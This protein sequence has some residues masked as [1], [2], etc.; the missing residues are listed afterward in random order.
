MYVLCTAMTLRP[1]P[2]S[3]SP[4]QL[5]EVL[6]NASPESNQIYLL[7]G[8]C[9]RGKGATKT[10][11]LV[12]PVEGKWQVYCPWSGMF[13]KLTKKPL[14]LESVTC[15][16]PVCLV[17]LPQSHPGANLTNQSSST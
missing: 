7:S 15:L 11:F 17:P 10:L 2:L 16:F 4:A 6:H 13:M 12:A 14:G 5:N 9:G 8:L 1:S 3:F